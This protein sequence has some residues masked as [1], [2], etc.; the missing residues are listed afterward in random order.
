M[1]GFPSDRRVHGFASSLL[2]LPRGDKIVHTVA[3]LWAASLAST[4]EMCSPGN[5][6]MKSD[7]VCR[8]TG[9]YVSLKVGMSQVCI[10]ST[11]ASLAIANKF[12][13]ETNFTE[14]WHEKEVL[15][16]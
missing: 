12:F 7:F 3:D 2:T 8:L 6:A 11:T 10:S 1:R 13:T 5:Q 9:L 4:S 15:L 14:H 16:G